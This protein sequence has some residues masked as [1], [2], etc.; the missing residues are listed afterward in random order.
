MLHTPTHPRA[1]AMAS[2]GPRGGRPPLPQTPRR[3]STLLFLV[4]LCGG[5]ACHAPSSA[6]GVPVHIELQ[7]NA[8]TAT[9]KDVTLEAVLAELQH[10]TGLRYVLPLT[11]AQR[12]VSGDFHAVPL[13]AALRQLLARVNYAMRVDASGQVRQIVI[14][15]QETP[16]PPGPTPVTPRTARGE[17]SP[18][19]VS[20][21]E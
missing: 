10:S 16:E 12:P 14:L 15:E 6:A 19:K 3:W 9:L 1:A 21:G 17:L 13:V 4:V 20:G 11:Q 5:I 8:M 7:H 2:C 18:P